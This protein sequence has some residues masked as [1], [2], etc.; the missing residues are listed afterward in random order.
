MRPSNYTPISTLHCYITAE[1][2]SGRMND[3]GIAGA[4]EELPVLLVVLVAVSLFSVSVAHAAATWGESDGTAQLQDESDAFS[5]MVRASDTL[6]IGGSEGVYDFN[7]LQIFSEADILD[8]FNSS[9][10]GF[11][12]RIS[13]Q[14]IDPSSGNITLGVEVQTSPLPSGGPVAC[15]HTC[16]NVDK[17]GSV[18]AARVTVTVWRS[19][20]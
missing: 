6:C 3:S 20:Q 8:E 13:I 1:R 19:D 17:G 5:E 10:L 11:D 14:C 2:N 18:G 16:V 9:V 4:F 12:Y 15:T 7:S